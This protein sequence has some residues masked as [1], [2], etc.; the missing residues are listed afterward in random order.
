MRPAES[1]HTR[2][3]PCPAVG[4]ST[5]VAPPVARSTLAM[6]LPAREA[7]QTSP[8]GVTVIPYGPRPR[9]DGKTSTVPVAGS[10]RPW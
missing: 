2:R 10:R 9:G 4:G 5:G 8:P 7:Y 1:D 6:W 3:A